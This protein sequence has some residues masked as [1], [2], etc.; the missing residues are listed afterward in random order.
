MNQKNSMG[1][2]I[3]FKDLDDPIHLF[4]E[5]FNEAKNTE[6]NDPN[7]LALAT[8]DK[9]GVPSVRMVL[10]KD[11]SENGF[12]IYTNLESQK[13]NQ[14]K[15][16][17]VASMC[18]HWKSLL[19][20]IR[21][22]GKILKVSDKEADKYFNSRDYES[23]IGAWSSKQSSKLKNRNQLIQKIEEFKKEFT[24]KNNVP[25]P[26]YW[27]GWRLEPYE[28]EFWLNGENRNHQRLKYLKLENGRWEKSLLS[29]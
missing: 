2:D 13:S 28:Y 7:A 5:W 18:F 1:L 11:Y 8:A 22:T 29:P 15:I 25:R 21:I 23:K 17:P 16:N 12:V 4:K 6:I 3:C 19:R 9:S 10:L 14:I 26:P 27:S 20:Q 24:D